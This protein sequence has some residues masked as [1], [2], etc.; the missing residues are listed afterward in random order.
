[1]T[2]VSLADRVFVVTGAGS[3]LGIGIAEA[4][5][6]AGGKVVLGDLRIA[7]VE[8]TAAKIDAGG[9]RTHP[10]ACDVADEAAVQMMVAAAVKRFGR[11][12]G[13]VNNAGV[14][15]LGG[16]LDE[17]RQ[18][19]DTQFGVNVAGL[20]QCCQAVARRLISQKTP[21]SIVNI[22]SNAGKVGFP[23]MAAYNASKAAVINL[24]R[25]LSAEWAPYGINV[26]AVCPGSVDTPMLKNVAVFLS[27]KLGKPV[28]EIYEMMVPQQLGRHIRPIEVGRVVAFLLSDEALIIRGQAINVDGGATPY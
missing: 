23:N 10:V 3:G 15:T 6:E 18:S 25:S 16:A 17:S 7:A 27:P 22:A 28:D 5:I 2:S 24:T 9:N 14:I 26:N 13:L 8:Q 4:L 12:D 21:G 19:I 11:V 20:Y 1:M